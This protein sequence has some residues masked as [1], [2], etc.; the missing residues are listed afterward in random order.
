MSSRFA[1][2][3]DNATMR[4]GSTAAGAGQKNNRKRNAL[5]DV[6]NKNGDGAAGGAGALKKMTSKMSSL[7]TKTS[8]AGGAAGVKQPSRPEGESQHSKKR[9]SFGRAGQNISSVRDIDEVNSKNPQYATE[10][11]NDMQAHF[12]NEEGRSAISASYMKSQTDIN[13]KMRAILIDW[14]IE[15]HL[16][17]KLKLETLYLTI[18]VIDRFLERTLV[19]RQKLQLVGVTALLLASKYEEIYPPE[20]R[21][22]VYI[23][24]K[25]YTRAQ[26][27]LSGVEGRGCEEE[28]GGEGRR[29]KNRAP[30]PRRALMCATRQIVRGNAA[31]AGL[32]ARAICSGAC[33]ACA[34]AYLCIGH[35]CPPPP[36]KSKRPR[37]YY[38]SSR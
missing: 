7:S 3:Q 10:Y 9:G 4:T 28:R 6:T 12:R 23:T 26:V 24:D 35:A 20:I 30:L 36:A 16:K 27:S 1:T 2:Y 17:F 15:V 5:G 32:L 33:S 37:F 38:F 19:S 22:L 25:A 18:N 8:A 11:I 34:G 13:E 14:L 29:K 31:T 21:E